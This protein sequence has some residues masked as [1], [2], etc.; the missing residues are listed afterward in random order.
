MWR[1]PYSCAELALGMAG[2]VLTARDQAKK[3]LA[4]YFN[5]AALLA[6]AVSLHRLGSV[7]LVSNR[8]ERIEPT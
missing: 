5:A 6:D 3:Y 7:G 4:E 1:R 8:E 2:P